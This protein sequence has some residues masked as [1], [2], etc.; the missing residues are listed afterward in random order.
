MIS[1]SHAGYNNFSPL[2]AIK[3][4][5]PHSATV[6]WKLLVTYRISQNSDSLEKKKNPDMSVYLETS[7]LGKGN[8]PS[9]FFG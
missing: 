7:I 9:V 4:F 5:T 1:I 6:V 8:K 2:L 3:L